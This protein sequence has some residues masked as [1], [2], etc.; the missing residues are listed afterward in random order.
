MTQPTRLRIAH[1]SDIH[2]GLESERALEWVRGEIARQE[3]DAVA[4]TGDF[5][6]RARRRKP[7]SRSTTG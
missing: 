6:M 3:P 4:I 1:L 2:F 5:T 7:R